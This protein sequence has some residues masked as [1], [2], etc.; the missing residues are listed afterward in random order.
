MKDARTIRAYVRQSRTQDMF[1]PRVLTV[2][3]V[4][5]ARRKRRAL[6]STFVIVP[7]FALSL[8]LANSGIA[9][10]YF[11]DLDKS[12]GNLL[13]AARLSFTLLVDH[14]SETLNAGEVPPP[15]EF[16]F[17]PDPGSLPIDYTV[18]AVA[19]GDSA[20]CDAITASG[21][22]PL[23]YAG[24]A[25]A[26]ASGPNDSL[27]H[28]FLTL[29]LPADPAGVTDGM[30]CDLAVTY[31]GYEHG[32]SPNTNYHQNQTI[33]LHLTAGIPA[34]EIDA[35]IAPQ[36]LFI[37]SEEGPTDDSP[38]ADD[39]P[40]DEPEDVPPPNDPPA[41]N[42]AGS[43]TQNSGVGNP[44]DTPPADSTPPPADPAPDATPSEETP[45]DPPPADPPASE[46]PPADVPA[47]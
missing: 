18:D 25:N 43:P 38:P 2:A 9:L 14:D 10:S 34:V 12:V 20:F 24:L 45:S 33:T 6:H 5:P 27:A 47:E 17:T 28:W 21:A 1:V 29:S 13:N 35:L 44:S 32:G 37:Q 46:T 40:A 8:M 23:P 16:T 3:S 39:P 42:P 11:S 41:D 15:F 22:A 26:L 30:T 4:D 7:V 36:S 31:H 19:T